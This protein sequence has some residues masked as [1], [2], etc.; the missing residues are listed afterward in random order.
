M[1]NNNGNLG[2]VI[3]G[4]VIVILAIGGVFWYQN[5]RAMQDDK[6]GSLYVGI[7]DA[8][9]D[10][11]NVN[12]V[13]MEVKKVEVHSATQG[14]V[15]ASS[16]SKSY[17]LLTLNSEGKTELYAKAK[18]VAGTYDRVRVTLGDTV[19]KTKTNGDVKAYSPS[20]QVVMNMAVNVQ[21][22]GNTNLRLDFLADKSLHSTSDNKYVF[23]PVVNAESH[24][25]AEVAVGD[26]NEVE[27]T[28]G[29]KDSSVSV[30]VDID[31][32]SRSNFSLT[33]GTDLKVDGSLLGS[34]KF[35]LGGKTYSENSS[36]QESTNGTTTTNAGAN[37]NV[38][39]GANANTGA[40][41][42]N[43]N[44]G[45]AVNLGY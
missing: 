6:G 5:E 35:M 4:A 34:V 24:S 19:V 14:W 33:T 21:K 22:E 20:N 1:D 30:G 2:G 18:V 13:N 31:G 3:I 12:E 44:V 32:T 16:D 25:G 45:G 26:S 10:I 42:A 38:N 9:A 28:G 7:T 39:T 11:S 27:S 43:V 15:T 41:N 23:A 40:G 8:T 29:M 36:A 17:N 37:T